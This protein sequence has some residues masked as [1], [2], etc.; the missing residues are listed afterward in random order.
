MYIGD[1][2][3]G[4]G[5]HHMI[6]EVVANSFD[7]YLAG[8]CTRID[9]RVEADGAIALADDGPGIAGESLELLLTRPSDLPTTD[10]HRPH[11]HLGQG[12]AGL[13]VV[14]ALSERFELV[15]VRDGIETRVLYARG[16]P[17]EPPASRS[18]VDGSGTRIH[19]RPDPL[20]FE[21]PRVSR[22]ALSKT[23]EDLTFLAPG[24]T[25]AWSPTST[26]S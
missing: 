5:A 6:L 13:F 18:G 21:H 25:I 26:A 14:N 11:V 7:Q 10:G 22:S 3:D 12:G 20:I 9:V 4:S 8:R 17:V 16:E 19:F 2:D 15:T 1:T 23:F 24:L